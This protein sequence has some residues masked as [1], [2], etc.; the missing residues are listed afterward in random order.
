MAKRKILK[1]CAMCF[2]IALLMACIVPCIPSYA[3]QTPPPLDDLLT[4]YPQQQFILAFDIG[5]YGVSNEPH[6]ITVPLTYSMLEGYEVP[7]LTNDGSFSIHVTWRWDPDF[8]ILYEVD[9][10]EVADYYE[11]Y[12]YRIYGLTPCITTPTDVLFHVACDQRMTIDY[13]CNYIYPIISD[14]VVNNIDYK[15]LSFDVYSYNF[16]EQASE[17]WDTLMIPAPG[18]LTLPGSIHKN[19]TVLICDSMLNIYGSAPITNLQFAVPA[20]DA[21]ATAGYYYQDLVSNWDS[22]FAVTEKVFIDWPDALEWFADMAH[23]V[24]IIELFPGITIGG[25]LLG[26]IIVPIVIIFLKIFAG[27]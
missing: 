21:D 27:G 3:S 23:E 10:S 18:D 19:G 5:E 26:F 25:I 22:S 8:N 2:A 1:I 9:L 12:D 6:S 11:V 16:S 4:V 13:R 7:V 24:L 20:L 14:S 15:S 17:E